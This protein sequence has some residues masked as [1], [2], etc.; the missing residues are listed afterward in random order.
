MENEQD[1]RN[2][3][4]IASIEKL[5][6][7]EQNS[8]LKKHIETAEAEN[9]LDLGNMYYASEGMVSWEREQSNRKMD[10]VR[11]RYK[12]QLC[13]LQLNCRDMHGEASRHAGGDK[14]D[15]KAS[16]RKDLRTTDACLQKAEMIRD[17]VSA[18][19]KMMDD[20]YFTK[21]HHC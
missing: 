15:V 2:A 7:E 18:R 20:L 11:K 1:K 17:M 14:R 12:T 6:L 8:L 19:I 3:E 13:K 21:N 5:P 9:K 16:C 10:E 4:F